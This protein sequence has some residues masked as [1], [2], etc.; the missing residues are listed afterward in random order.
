MRIAEIQP[1]P[2]YRLRVRFD[3]GRTVVY[4]VGE[5][6]EAIPSYAALRTIPGL[7]EQVQLDASRTCVF[8]K[9]EIDLPSDAICE[10]GREHPRG[11][12]IAARG[13]QIT[14]NMKT[15]ASSYRGLSL[16]WSISSSSAGRREKP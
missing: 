9:D 12:P 6:I 10:Y 16:A 13:A 8:W 14:V 7:F 15:Q 1:L 2:G 4:D 5:D 11:R 3:D